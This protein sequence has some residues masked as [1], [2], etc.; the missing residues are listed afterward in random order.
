VVDGLQ[1]RPIEGTDVTLTAGTRTRGEFRCSD[2]GYGVMVYR[3]LPRCP[4][5]FGDTW[6][7]TGWSPFVHAGAITGAPRAPVS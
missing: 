6:E 3:E 5:C 7:E 4:M 2:C 1:P